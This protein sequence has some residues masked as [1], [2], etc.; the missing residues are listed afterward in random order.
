MLRTSAHHG[1]HNGAL[2][3]SASDKLAWRYDKHSMIS[4][5]HIWRYDGD[6]MIGSNSGIMLH[7]DKWTQFGNICPP[8]AGHQAW[9]A[10]KP[11]TYDR[12][13][14]KKCY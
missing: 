12:S 13:V 9:R 4:T 7:N 1:E 5:G 10:I 14:Q 2:S 8:V 6:D 11:G 3:A